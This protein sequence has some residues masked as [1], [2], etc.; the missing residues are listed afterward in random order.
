MG[1]SG[2]STGP[3]WVLS[4]A[5]VL[6][7]ARLSGTADAPAGLRELIANADAVFHFIP[8]ADEIE[9]ALSRL[10]GAGLVTV[11]DL[12]IYVERLGR[13]LVA[14]ARG[15]GDGDPM[16]RVVNL[17]ALLQHFPTEPVPWHLDRDVYEEVTLEYRHSL[18]ETYRAGRRR[19]R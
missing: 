10:V 11:G 6:A 7:T 17:L 5:V 19:R 15:N 9:G 4:D 3:R 1:E 12:G 14:R 8:S 13:E 2:D 16:A 18:W